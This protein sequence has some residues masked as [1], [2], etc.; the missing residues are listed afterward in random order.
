MKKLDALVIKS[1]FCVKN[2]IDD[3]LS[4]KR[5]GDSYFVAIAFALLLVIGIAVIYRDR[6]GSL[7]NSIFNKVDGNIN[8]T[9]NGT[10]P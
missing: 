8:N 10:T 9:I 7:M 6:L 2:K 4:R 3:L 1:K 5:K